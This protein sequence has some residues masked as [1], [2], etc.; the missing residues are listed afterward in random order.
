[1]GAEAPPHTP[2]PAPPPSGLWPQRTHD[3]RHPPRGEA[4]V[5]GTGAVGLGETEYGEACAERGVR[6][7]AAA[8][9][10]LESGDRG[11]ERRGS[12]HALRTVKHRGRLCG[13][14]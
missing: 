1:V 5:C 9:V 4:E 12:G 6:R 7:E 8:V 11:V 2:T 13:D 14:V 10:G 3:L